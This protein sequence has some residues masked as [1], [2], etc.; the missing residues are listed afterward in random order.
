M[1]VATANAAGLSYTPQAMKRIMLDLRNMEKSNLTRDGIFFHYDDSNMGVIRAMIIGPSETPYEHGFY[2]FNI[3]FP[4][5]Y[6]FQPP[7]VHFETLDSKVRFN[8]NLYTNGK[9]CLSLINTWDGPKWT[10]CQSLSSVLLSI[11]AMIL[12]KDPL[13]NEPCYYECKDRSILDPYNMVIT[14]ENYRVAIKNMLQHPP[15]GFEVFLPEMKKYIVRNYI[16]I[17]NHLEHLKKTVSTAVINLSYYGGIQTNVNYEPLYMNFQE[18]V[19]NLIIEMPEEVQIQLDQK[20]NQL[21][22][23]V[24]LEPSSPISADVPVFVV[25]QSPVIALEEIPQQQLQH[26][27]MSKKYIKASMRLKLAELEQLC[28][29]NG[30]VIHIRKKKEILEQIAGHNASLTN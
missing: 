30:I 20:V 4:Y 21:D 9:V 22:T 25:E 11:Q 3:T 24:I 2:F 27:H 13:R 26:S 16:K 15:A 14:F 19:G 5:N 23:A 1:S 10:A 6:P 12:V 7:A 18:I 29:D 17:M 28:Q 8:P